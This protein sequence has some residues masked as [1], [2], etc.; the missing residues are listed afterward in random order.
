ME[1]QQPTWGSDGEA[2][3]LETLSQSGPD[4]IDLEG[5]R[6]KQ[7]GPSATADSAP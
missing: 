7:A 1:N 6:L 2:P 3:T 5:K 4:G